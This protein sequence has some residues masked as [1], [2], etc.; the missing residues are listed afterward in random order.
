MEL[1]MIMTLFPITCTNLC[2]CN[3]QKMAA[4]IKKIIKVYGVVGQSDN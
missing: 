1:V 2:T 3:A 4:M